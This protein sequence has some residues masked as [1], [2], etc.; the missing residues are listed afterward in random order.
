MITQRAAYAG[1]ASLAIAALLVTV[2]LV[3]Q[4]A[5][6]PTELRSVPPTPSWLVAPP[7]FSLAKKARVREVEALH[8]RD[9]NFPTVNREGNI[10]G[11]AARTGGKAKGVYPRRYSAAS[12]HAAPGARGRAATR[13]ATVE[14]PAD[15]WQQDRSKMYTAVH[16]FHKYGDS[17]L[18]KLIPARKTAR[19]YKQA[20]TKGQREI[21]RLKEAKKQ[22][23]LDEANASGA[24]SAVEK[25]IAEQ[26]ALKRDALQA[27]D[28]GK[29]FAEKMQVNDLKRKL[30]LQE[31]RD[32][33]RENIVKSQ[34]ASLAQENQDLRKKDEKISMQMEEVPL[35][36]A[37]A[38]EGNLMALRSEI[39]ELQRSESGNVEALKDEVSSMKQQM[40]TLRSAAPN[41]RRKATTQI[42]HHAERKGVTGFD[43]VSSAKQLLDLVRQESQS[44]SDD[45]AEQEQETQ[46]DMQQDLQAQ[47]EQ[48]HA[49]PECVPCDAGQGCHA[50]C[51]KMTA[52]ERTQ[53]RQRQ[54]QRD[55]RANVNPS[56][57]Q[58]L[59]LFKPVGYNSVAM[60]ADGVMPKGEE[61]GSNIK[62]CR[63]GNCEPL[64][65]EGVKVDGWG[66]GQSDKSLKG[67]YRMLPFPHLDPSAENSVVRAMN[68]RKGRFAQYNKEG[69]EGVFTPGSSWGANTKFFAHD[70]SPGAK[71]LEHKGVTIDKWPVNIY[72]SMPLPGFDKTNWNHEKNVPF[73]PA[74]PNK[75]N[76]QSNS[77]LEKAGVLVNK[78]PAE[79]FTGE[80][81]TATVD[82][83]ADTRVAYQAVPEY[84][85]S[86]IARQEKPLYFML[87][88]HA[89]MAQPQPVVDQKR[90]LE[91]DDEYSQEGRK[92][93]EYGFEGVQ[94]TLGCGPQG[95]F[96]V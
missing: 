17:A 37:S 87:R 82:G 45:N 50:G 7:T 70:G 3:G 78:W 83:Q 42:E 74:N 57:D 5:S 55:V 36:S 41:T 59:S 52:E 62:H 54:I 23:Q 33:R 27:R 80:R 72:K 53:L 24:L 20:L 76:R 65:T 93:G 22:G 32:R 40:E 15:E 31:A 8:S 58:K 71:K 35:P 91:Y 68:Q 28:E 16:E 67:F 92:H 85:R 94:D 4:Q 86:G 84:R 1:V 95:C 60:G 63:S 43:H 48:A 10:E 9:A 30:K 19:A 51:R 73:S 61:F 96:E 77:P 75:F 49:H 26:D 44:D 34:V 12:S 47:A 88:P 18:E 13:K 79:K 6:A 2:T 29:E 46:A 64:Q 66:F 90:G 39:K 21:N 56:N 38:K 14:T 11:A 89:N 69:Q 81:E 25:G